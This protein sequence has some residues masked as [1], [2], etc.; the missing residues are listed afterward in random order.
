MT[1]QRAQ[2]GFRAGRIALV[3]AALAAALAVGFAI[4][5]S[6]N[7]APEDAERA[8]GETASPDI[9]ELEE[10]T[11][12]NPDDAAAWQ[13]LGLAG[14]GEGRFADAARAFGRAAALDPGNAALWSALGEA[15]I[16]ASARDP[17]PADAVEA[18]EKA[19]ALDPKDPRAR[20]FLA[21]KKDVGGDHRGALDEWLELLEETPAD[22]PWRPDLIRTIGQVGKINGIDVASRLAAAG[23][24]SPQPQ[25]PAASRAIPGPSA[26]DLAA[27]TSMRPGEQRDMAEGMVTRLEERLKGDPGNL[28]GWVML[29]RSRVTLGQMDKATKALADAVAANP[30]RAGFLK[31]QAAV[32]GVK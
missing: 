7:A 15:L 21:V 16:Y 30:A 23:A 9:A 17:M 22:A 26:Q 8:A 10:R 25:V 29:M 6:Q 2:N 19:I 32:L 4:S 1:Q 11:A 28:D 5:R 13:R 3:L 20:Y 18:F 24:K 12:A 27:A 31:Q 14:F